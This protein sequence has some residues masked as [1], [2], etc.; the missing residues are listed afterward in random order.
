[1]KH[2]DSS[3]KTFMVIVLVDVVVVRITRLIVL[4][5]RMPFFFTCLALA[6]PAVAAWR[7]IATCKWA[8]D[9]A[10]LSVWGSVI[11]YMHQIGSWHL[12]A[13]STWACNP[14]DTLATLPYG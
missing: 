5:V 13:T 8:F 4:K 9:P 12:V 1:M 3:H 2:T 6:L 7:L 10:R 14:A 11:S